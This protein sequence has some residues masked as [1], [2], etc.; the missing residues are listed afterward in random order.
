MPDIGSYSVLPRFPGEIA[1]KG[2]DRLLPNS[3]SNWYSR[4]VV[5]LVGGDELFDN[6]FIVDLL[7]LV[8]KSFVESGLVL[9]FETKKEHAVWALNPDK[10]YITTELSSVKLQREIGSVNEADYDTGAYGSWHIP[11]DW[12]DS[13][14][15]LPSLDQVSHNDQ[16]SITYCMD[17]FPRQSMYKDFYLK[18]QINR[19]IG[20]E[21]TALLERDYRE[22]LEKRF[23]S[24]ASDRKDWYE[25]LLSATPTLEMGIDIGDLSSVLLCSVPPGQANY[26]QRAGRG[27]RR[28]GNSFVLTLANGHPHD[29]YF[30]ADPVKMMAGDI[31][32][33]AIFLNASMVLKRQLLAFCFD[34]WGVHMNG[35]QVIP[36]SMQPVIDAVEKN[37]QKRFPYTLLEFISLRRDELWEGFLILLGDKV[38][39]AT[40]LRLKEYMLA[41]SS[42]DDALHVHVLNRIQQ[43]VGERNTLLKHQKDL[44][45]ELRSLQNRPHD[46]ARDELEKELNT[47][48][49]GMKRLKSQLNWKKTL[50]FFTDDGLL[51]NYAFPEEG[52]TLHSVIYRRLKAPKET[53][54][55]KTTN[56]DSTAYEYSR[57]AHSALSELAPESIF[58]ASNRKVQID[59]VEMAKG[60]NLEYW[61]LCPSCNYSEQIL[62]IDQDIA[63]PRCNDSM[64]SNT[65]Q[66]IPMVRLTQVYASTS[67]A[68]AFI[69]DDS[70]TREPTFFNRQML[71]DFDPEDIT[72][73]YAMKTE[74]KPFGFEFIKKASFKEIN[75][76]KQGGSDQVFHVA[77]QE[78]ARPGFRLCKECGTV[79]HK[80]NTAEHLYLYRQYESEAIRILMPRLSI[81]DREEQLQ[82]FVA[83]LQLGLKARYGG[84]VDHLHIMISDEPIA[85]TTDRASYLVIYDTVPGGTGYLHDLL[86]D[87]KNIM[88]LLALSRE[89]MASCSCQEL[90]DVDGCYNCLYAYKNSYGMEHTSR[91]T[92][93]AML[94]EILD[95][96]VELE[97]V[98]HLGKI[99]KNVW[100]D[101]ELE[102]RFPEAIQQLS[103]HKALEGKRIR[104]STDIIN[105]K[106]GFKLEIGDRIY[107]VE[108]HPRL[109]EADGVAYPCEPDFIITLDRESESTLPVAV[110]LDGYR[111]HKN[112][113]HEDLMKRQGIFLSR[114]YLTWSLTWYDINHVFAGNEVKVP[115]VF[116][117]NIE[118]SNKGYIRQIS[119]S[120]GLSDHNEIAE[121]SPLLML[122]KYLSN[123][124]KDNWQGYAALRVLSWLDQNSMQDENVLNRLKA[125][126]QLFPGQFMDQMSSIKLIFSTINTLE[127]KPVSF[128]TYIAGG[129]DVV[130][131]L[132]V[133]ELMLAVVY[134]ANEPDSEVTKRTWQKLLQVINLG[135]FL[136]NFFAGT[137][138]GIADGGFSKLSWGA[139]KDK[140]VSSEWDSILALVDEDISD[141][142]VEV[143]NHDIEIP[144]VGYEL[145]DETGAVVAEAELAWLSN[146]VALMMP[147]QMDENKNEFENQGWLVFSNN[148]EIETIIEKLRG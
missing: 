124:G 72:E 125:D 59:R 48:L 79:Q 140:V 108:I 133:D 136:P 147:Y 11:A 28:D 60:E 137:E 16:Y 76:G 27:G 23:M 33:P 64:W 129:A 19:V 120:K 58:Y 36:G 121:L 83:S 66:K 90:P 73:A 130:R 34:Q 5:Q 144:D 7:K 110:F 134:Q 80:R 2:L 99:S 97:R 32:A 26:L 18:G 54:D 145:E 123:P 17:A 21:H 13:L 78:L 111:Y 94:A 122:I 38:T 1:E 96:N 65:S 49:E 142:L 148:T 50:N 56:Y 22:A 126:S 103:Q 132:N 30:Y 100:A 63:C 77:G 109:G 119:E 68:D 85:D 40:K 51:P 10:L 15:G 8:M 55:G 81:A 98:T 104:T 116:R 53:E 31:Q 24:K 29:L 4:W 112:I 41:T 20:H 47:E 84:K 71:I 88:E 118:K 95:E 9:Q 57:P 43:V 3:Q 39:E 106:T 82:S 67:E 93:L 127:E 114:K 89:I 6:H 35:Q 62:G 44:E 101:S 115:N 12:K 52:T 92:A 102:A 61:R 107:S 87:S 37:N 45:S 74:T 91:S 135:Q 141:L 128:K 14:I 46:E 75:F 105:G 146:K 117:E 139:I 138:K 69:G 25:N 131:T 113:I 86:K 70:D 143:L 42:D